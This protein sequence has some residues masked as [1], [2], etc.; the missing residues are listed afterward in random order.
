MTVAAL[1]QAAWRQLFEGNPT[2]ALV[3]TPGDWVMVAVTDAYL[4][5][6]GTSRDRLIG[7]SVFEVFPDPPDDPTADGVRALRASLERVV[8]TRTRDVMPVQRYPV[9]IDGRFEERFWST[10]NAPVL[11]ASGEVVAVIHRVED[12]TEY[13]RLREGVGGVHTSPD[14]RSRL[15]AELLSRARDLQAT[16]EELR[17]T[18]A[19]VRATFDSA[20]VGL[21]ILN[22]DGTVALANRGL[23]EM[24]GYDEVEFAGRQMA[25]ITYVD[26]LAA[27]EQVLHDLVTQR[28]VLGRFQKRYHR[29]DGTLLWV[30][31]SIAPLR[32]RDGR[33]RHLVKVMEDITAEREAEEQARQSTSLLRLAGRVGRIGGWAIDVARNVVEWSQEI[34]DILEHPSDAL[35]SLDGSIDRY[36]PASR[37]MVKD[38]IATTISTGRPF[39][40]ELEIESYRGRWLTVRAV[41][42]AV[43]DDAGAVVRVNGALQDIT[44]LKAAQRSAQEAGA[45][46]TEA[47]EQMPTALY[48]LDQA[49][50]FTYLNRE[51]ERILERSRDALVGRVIWDEFPEAR[52]SALYAVYRESME[53]RT[54]RTVE[55]YYPPLQHWFEITSH[56]SPGGMIAYFRVVTDRKTA[57]E[58]RRASAE[59]IA[60]QAA[61][62]DETSDAILVRD[63]EG[64]IQFWNRGAERLYGW[65]AEEIVGRD[66][67]PIAYRDPAPFEAA[68]VV[69]L[70]S[71]EWA[72][73]LE[74]LRRD[75]T[76]VTVFSRWTLRR[77]AE[78]TPTSVLVIDSDVTERRQLERQ[79]LRSQRLESIGTL[80]GGIA[81][82]LNNALAP[83]LMSIELLQ[84]E[85][86][87]T[88]RSSLLRTIEGSA[89]R[90]AEMVRQVLTFA[91]GAEGQRV[92]V[93]LGHLLH[94]CAKVADET[95]LKE[96]VVRTEIPAT[97][98]M[99]LGDPTQLHQVMINL[100]VN[101]RDAMPRGGT[102]VMRATTV[103]IDAQYAAVIPEATPGRYVRVEVEDSGDGM[104]PEVLEKVFDPFFTTKPL[105]KG[106]GLG[107]PTSK[108]IVEG[109]G[110]FVRIYSEPGRGTRVQVYLP[111]TTS[112]PG[113]GG[114][115]A[116]ARSLPRGNGE[117]ILLVDDEPSVREVTR[118]TLEAFGYRVVTASDGAEGVAT[119]AMRRDEVALVLTD[120]MMPV[121]DGNALITVLQR[122]NPGVLII[123]ASG[124]QGQGRGVHGDVPGVGAFLAKPYGASELILAV[125]HLLGRGGDDA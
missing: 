32:D 72:G 97:L 40:L 70:A 69:V 30:R 64:H 13:V 59:R 88:E 119:Y 27:T 82:D 10:V 103:D 42:E 26:D 91:R 113:A 63:L 49:W 86:D 96:V 1:D 66:V 77:D 107:L 35:P 46:L 102:L 110:G 21:A 51:A 83:I 92:P 98:D 45:R 75:Q 122:M 43:R 2:N 117:L 12:I 80:A 39:D 125:A 31:V 100:C 36:A 50:R 108:A 34:H 53:Q 24:L 14:D 87:A 89:R 33:L 8:T 48:M 73:E 5:T 23:C 112:V 37:D 3:L 90:G 47:L 105:G 71:G 17:T 106:T 56:P 6:T 81:H 44:E 94:D 52:D 101:A 74:Q 109:H 121:M 29:K 85:E 4:A 19:R 16:N 104:A 124:L 76:P 62:L 15:E 18:Q 54:S 79:F 38:A 67:L 65:T 41:G 22:L 78:G 116:A 55:F 114:E 58:E 111:A 95:L 99:V 28:S 118:Q 68:M 9:Q 25:S 7:Q 123:A 84:Y 115:V 120:I 57:E 60:E 20:A 93:N 61:L 11:N